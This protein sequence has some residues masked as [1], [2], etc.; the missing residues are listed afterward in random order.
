MSMQKKEGL[1]L[2]VPGCMP[3]KKRLHYVWYKYMH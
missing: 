2:L 3:H 1:V